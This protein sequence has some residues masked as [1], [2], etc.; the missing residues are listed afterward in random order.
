MISN[1][2]THTNQHRNRCKL[3]RSTNIATPSADIA[4]PSAD[5]SASVWVFHDVSQC[6]KS[7][8]WCFTGGSWCFTC[9]WWCFTIFYKCFMM[10]YYVYQ[11]FTMFSELR[12]PQ[13]FAITPQKPVRQKY[14]LQIGKYFYEDSR[15]SYFSS[16]SLNMFSEGGNIKECY[17]YPRAILNIRGHGGQLIMNP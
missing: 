14:S 16:K 1:S 9:V 2:V 17:K 6:F 11:C 10:F 3:R 8:S 5:V 4:M 7:V 13:W 15:I 12:R